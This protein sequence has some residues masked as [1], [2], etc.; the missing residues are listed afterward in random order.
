[1][2]ITTARPGHLAP[3]VKNLGAIL[4]GGLAPPQPNRISLD[5][6]RFTLILENG[7][8][9]PQ[10]PPS[11]Q[12][13]AIIVG[14]NANVSRRYFSEDAVYDRDNPNAPICW[15][16][17]GVGPSEKVQSPISPTC[18]QCPNSKWDKIMPQ[19]GSKVP[20]CQHRKKVALLVAGAGA[21]PF[22]LDIPPASLKPWGKYMYRLGSELH[23]SPSD[24]VTLIK[25][26]N[27]QLVFEDVLWVPENMIAGVVALVESGETDRLVGADD[28]PYDFRQLPAPERRDTIGYAPN[29]YPAMTS[30]QAEAALSGQEPPKERKPR[31]PRQPRQE[32]VVGPGPI[33]PTT[34]TQPTT[35]TVPATFG[36]DERNP[37]PPNGGFINQSAPTQQPPQFGMAPPDAAAPPSNLGSMLDA[38]FALRTGPR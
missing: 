6:D 1:M 27:K 30:H 15:S 31:Q 36:F 28:R 21:D 23:C 22:L 24:V 4:A 3:T 2:P 19:T 20:A 32:T 7:Q 16:D 35:A 12:I 33:P 10:V 5:N 9:H 8:V 11:L 17:N 26:E 25:F 37:P 18:A 29:P 14:G 38:A 13:Q 34:F